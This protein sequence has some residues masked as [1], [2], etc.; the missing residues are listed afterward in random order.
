VHPP[1]GPR[2]DRTRR[3]PAGQQGRRGPWRSGRWF[4]GA[5]RQPRPGVER[6]QTAVFALD[7]EDDQKTKLEPSSRTPQPGQDG[8]R[9]ESESL[10]GRERAQKVMGFQPRPAGEG[11]RRAHRRAAQTL[12]KN[13]ATLMAKQMVENYRRRLGELDLSDDQKTKVDAVL[14]DDRE[15]GDRSRGPGAARRRRARPGRRLGRGGRSPRSRATP[16]RRSTRSS[17]RAAA[18]VSRNP[19]QG[20]G[21]GARTPRRPGRCRRGRRQRQLVGADRGIRSTKRENAF[22]V[23]CFLFLVLLICFGCGVWAWVC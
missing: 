22:P 13:Q 17:P 19:P 16:A 2:A 18:E 3:Q 6:I 12:R 1:H 23:S 11:Q 20:R 10:Q 7:S 14:A 15:E 4:G 9:R 8:R 5:V 21:Q